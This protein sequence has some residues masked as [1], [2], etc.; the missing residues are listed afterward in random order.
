[1]IRLRRVKYS[2]VFL[3]AYAI[4]LL[5][6]IL[7]LTGNYNW[8]INPVVI[9]LIYIVIC[10]ALFL[11][12]RMRVI[13]A[14]SVAV[15]CILSLH[16]IL[17]GKV[18]VNDQITALID[19]LY[20]SQI[21]FMLILVVTLF[22]IRKYDL[23][24][25]FIKISF[26]VL[27]SVLFVQF[28]INI[29][30]LDL[31]NIVNI[32]S[33]DKRTRGDFGFGHYNTLGAACVCELILSSILNKHS[34]RFIRI[35][36]YGGR[37]LAIVM[38]LCSA[39]RSSLTSLAVFLIVYLS[40]GINELNLSKKQM[41]IIKFVRAI[42]VFGLISLV[43]LEIDFN[44]ILIESQRSLVFNH[45]LPLFLNSGRVLLGLGFA[46]NTAYGTGET[47]YTTYWIDNGYIYYLITTGILGFMLIISAI[48]IIFVRL[49]KMRRE[50]FGK[51][52]FSL[53]VMYLYG[54]LFEV[55]IFMSGAIVNYIYLPIFI[56]TMSNVQR[57]GETR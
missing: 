22:L 4:L 8:P 43:F 40:I 15:I 45:A 13:S 49:Y 3:G 29:S 16:T 7:V 55:T 18:F 12:N 20:Q 6:R 47:P 51:Y 53:F 44:E 28:I 9:E 19:S 39:S 33:K 52:V 23:L 5:S 31:S 26:L 25:D 48:V 38:L 35:V 17:W 27:L 54:S 56:I 32:M 57:K 14:S 34:S 2:S 24:Y 42:L 36:I 21:M 41:V 11:N 10:G 46:S 1:M 30:D 50:I 37:I